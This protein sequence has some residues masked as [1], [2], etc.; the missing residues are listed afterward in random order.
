MVTATE[1]ERKLG[2]NFP[3]NRVLIQNNGIEGI[4]TIMDEQGT[5]YSFNG[6]EKTRIARSFAEFLKNI[7]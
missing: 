4:L 3:V 2:E 5:V 6:K 7:V 1:N